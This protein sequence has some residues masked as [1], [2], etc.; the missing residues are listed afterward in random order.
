VAVGE[1]ADALTGGIRPTD[2]RAP[3]V[4]EVVYEPGRL[5]RIEREERD[6]ERRG[7]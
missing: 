5:E 3:D 1:G 6:R 7:G 4:Q 2:P